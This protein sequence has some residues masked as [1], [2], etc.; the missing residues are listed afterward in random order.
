MP[1]TTKK[2]QSRKEVPQELTWDLSLI[3]A[4]LQ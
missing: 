1:D 2:L 3:Y 4:R